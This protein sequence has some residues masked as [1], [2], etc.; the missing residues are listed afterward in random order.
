M[1]TPKLESL[2]KKVGPTLFARAQ[3]VLKDDAQAQE[4]VQLVV[5][6]LSRLGELDDAVLL[7]LGRDLLKKRLEGRGTALDSISKTKE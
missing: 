1:P 2:Y 3:R 6:D 7:K 5:I 4:L